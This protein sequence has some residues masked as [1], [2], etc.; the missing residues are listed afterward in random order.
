MTQMAQ[1]GFGCG[2][3]PAATISLPPAFSSWTSM[4]SGLLFKRNTVLIFFSENINLQIRKTNLTWNLTS[5]LITICE[6]LSRF[7]CSNFLICKM[8]IIKIP[9]SDIYCED[10]NEIIGC[11]D[12]M[13]NVIKQSNWVTNVWQ[14]CQRGGGRGADL[15]NFGER[16]RICKTKG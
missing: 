11:Q 13:Q 1:V 3:P 4:Y 15:S 9:T 5:R 14:P 16:S 2:S 10:G 6:T 8:R 12:G 7:L